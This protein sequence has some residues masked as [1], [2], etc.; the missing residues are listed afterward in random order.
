MVKNR[1][2]NKKIVEKFSL[3]TSIFTFSSFYS[4][5][6]HEEE[7]DAKLVEAL[8]HSEFLH[9]HVEYKKC[10]EMD[11]KWAIWSFSTMLKIA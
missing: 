7:L 8:L 4:L 6:G 11:R 5:N 2:R 10:M 1:K 9:L 3:K